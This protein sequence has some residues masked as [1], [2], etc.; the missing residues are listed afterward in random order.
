MKIVMPTNFD[1]T[2]YDKELLSKN[3][4]IETVQVTLKR[5]AEREADPENPN[6]QPFYVRSVARFQNE[7]GT[8][9]RLQMDLE[10]IGQ[11]YGVPEE[12]INE[13]FFNVSCSKTKL[14]ECLKG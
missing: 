6:G 11:E 2:D 1:L 10:R 4:D 12:K 3:L 5:D 8:F 14:I 9:K 13:I 7:E